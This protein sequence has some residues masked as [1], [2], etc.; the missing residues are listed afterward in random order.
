M[1]QISKNVLAALLVITILISITGTWVALSS[2]T[3]YV[4]V[5][6]GEESIAVG[7][8]SAVDDGQP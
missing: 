7:K 1:A 5:P 4:E 3:P 8:V 6:I 2:L